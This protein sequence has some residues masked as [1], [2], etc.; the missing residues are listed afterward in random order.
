MPDFSQVCEMCG[1]TRYRPEVLEAKVEGY[2][3]AGILALTVSEAISQFEGQGISLVL[4][5][6]ANTGLQYMTLGQSLDTLSGG[7]IQRVKL[8]R[9]LTEDV[10]DHIFIFDEPTTGF[11]K[12]IYLY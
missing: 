5:A 4:Q 1:G 12:M 3:I 11:M 7:E 2:S 9:Y 6:L 8:S 10:H